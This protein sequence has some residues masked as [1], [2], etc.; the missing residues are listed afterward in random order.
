[1]FDFLCAMQIG[2]PYFWLRDCV[3]DDTSV[4]YGRYV[5]CDVGIR[6]QLWSIIHKNSCLMVPSKMQDIFI[7]S[8]I[9]LYQSFRLLAFYH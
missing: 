6:P 7:Q 9:I 4:L 5:L 1:M 3:F 2:Q 8:K